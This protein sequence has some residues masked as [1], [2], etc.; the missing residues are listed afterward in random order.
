MLARLAQLLDRRLGE[1]DARIRELATL[2]EEIE[3][4]RDRVAHRAAGGARRE[5]RRA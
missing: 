5:G 1:L 2:R 3:R 4:Y